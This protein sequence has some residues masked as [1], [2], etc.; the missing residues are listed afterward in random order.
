MAFCNKAEVFK[1]EGDETSGLDS[2]K[3]VH[4]DTG[5][6]GGAARSIDCI[7]LAVPLAVTE[8]AVGGF[9]ACAAWN[10]CVARGVVVV[11]T[12]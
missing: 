5:C 8:D 10:V 3:V 9:R 1:G 4:L 7:P 12:A 11:Y 6:E 2:S